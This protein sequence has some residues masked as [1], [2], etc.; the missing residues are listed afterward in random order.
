[1]KKKIKLSKAECQKFLLKKKIKLKIEVP[2]TI[3]FTKAKYLKNSKLIYQSV[4]KKFKKKKIVI[5]SSSKKEDNHLT[6]LAGK[7]K[8]FLNIELNYKNFKKYTGEVIKDLELNDQIFI[9]NFISKPS[10][11]GVIFT[12]D[13][14]NNSPYYIINYDKSKKTNLVTSGIKNPSIKKKVIFRDTK[15][16]P[17]E[18]SGIIKKVKGIEK[19]FNSNSLDIEFAVKNKKLI[20]FQ[21]RPLVFKKKKQK[22]IL[23]T[24]INLEK[25]I[26]KINLK[27]PLLAGKRTFLSNM[28][29]W[30]PAEMIGNK[31][32][33]LALS[34]YSELI[35]D[36]IW[37]EQRDKYGYKNVFPNPLMIN[38]GG[39][40]YID[41]RVDINSFLPK[42][43]DKKL[44]NKI[45]NYYL[46][47]LNKNP[48][49]HDKIEF[50][51]IETCYDFNSKKNLQN[52]L[53]G[54]DLTNYLNSLKHITNF[55]ISSKLLDEDI[56]KNKILDKNITNIQN[57]KLSHIQ[58]IFFLIQDCKKYGTLPFAGIARC[59]FITTKLLKSLN[60]MKLISQDEYESIFRS[61]NTI[62]TQIKNDFE[63]YLRGKINKNFFLK[64]YGHIRP[65]MY[66]IKS[67]NY[68]ENFY[69]YF[70]KK[71]RTS[72]KKISSKVKIIKS[73]KNKKIIDMILKKNNLNFNSNHLIKVAKKSIFYRE[74]SKYIFSKSLN[75][76]F[77]NL[78]VL[79]KEI[80]IKRNDFEYISIKNIIQYYHNLQ[81][82]KLK[83][84]MLNEIREQKISEQIT[85][86]IKLPDFID[87][88]KNV[89]FYKE[90]LIKG[91]FVT[92]NKINSEVIN[93]KNSLKKNDLFK[94]IVLIENADPGFDYIFSYGIV[95][96][97]TKYGGA[98]SHMAIRCLELGIPAVI[99]VGEK[100]FEELSKSFFIEIDCF[101]KK[102]DIIR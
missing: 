52:F 55:A 64:K 82:K 46:N 79:S 92:T 89:Y 1:M 66:S 65:S 32:K 13:P 21:V 28:S 67:K 29:D 58:K 27:N 39:I 7:Y 101:Q 50:E 100:Q 70:P 90:Q 44:E 76:I 78:Q 71:N 40:P 12:L 38:L 10:I 24:L 97:I 80:K 22:K 25:K 74:Y 6:S 81:T 34:L 47:K 87:N 102:I 96:L 77:E 14:S 54:K 93:L 11:S 9:Q 84:V 51:I 72:N 61:I 19:L 86:L 20:I 5:R 8:S 62:S 16:L 98:N 94:K 2:Q 75:K 45:V 95:G 18:F 83:E 99:G 30:N 63:K 33:P 37:A 88:Y 41:L 68:K 4:K 48:S 49:L 53:R 36:S 17:K 56:K 26:K 31:P 23:Y 35:T 91:N 3:L 42:Q 73:F 59:S 15:F 60:Q 85:N 57:S 43:L 69:N